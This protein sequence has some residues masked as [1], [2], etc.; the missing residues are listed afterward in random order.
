MPL[1][2]FGKSFGSWDFGMKYFLLLALYM[3]LSI[4]SRFADSY[5]EIIEVGVPI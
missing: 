2:K 3:M 1:S 4:V 5:G